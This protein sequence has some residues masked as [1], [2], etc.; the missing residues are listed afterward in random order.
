VFYIVQHCPKL[1]IPGRGDRARDHD[2][3]AAGH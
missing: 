3:R 1:A 2:R